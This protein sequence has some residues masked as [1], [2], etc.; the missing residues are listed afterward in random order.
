M[1]TEGVDNGG[2]FKEGGD[3]PTVGDDIDG[4]FGLTSDMSIVVGEGVFVKISAVA[5]TEGDGDGDLGTLI[6]T[7]REDSL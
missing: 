7:M 2:A 1:I 4:P 5:F 6:F 3:M